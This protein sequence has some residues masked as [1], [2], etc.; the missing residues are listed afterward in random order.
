MCVIYLNCFIL[1]KI[2]QKKKTLWVVFLF[3][4]VYRD[5]RVF[6]FNWLSLVCDFF[7]V[8]AIVSWVFYN[9]DNPGEITY[10][11]QIWIIKAV[12]TW[13]LV[14]IF[15]GGPICGLLFFH[16]IEDNLGYTHY[17]RIRDYG[18]CGVIF[19]S[20]PYLLGWF[21]VWI[22]LSAFA[23]VLCE[24]IFFAPF[25]F[26]CW[27]V[28]HERFVDAPA[29]MYAKKVFDFILDNKSM[30]TKADGEY[31]I[32]LRDSKWLEENT[33]YTN[34]MHND[35][36]NHLQFRDK[37]MLNT[38]KK[39]RLFRLAYANYFL[40]SEICGYKSDVK[41]A[42]YL[43]DELNISN[44]WQN[45]TCATLRQ[46]C[47]DGP[48]DSAF[49]LR[50]KREWKEMM[51]DF[52]DDLTVDLHGTNMGRDYSDIIWDLF[53]IIYMYFMTYVGLPLFFLSRLFS[54]FFPVISMVYLQFDL[55][56]VSLLQLV[57]TV[58][59]GVLIFWWIIAL[60]KC[61]QFYYWSTHLFPGDESM[62]W[63]MAYNI[64]FNLRRLNLMQKYYNLRNDAVF[65]EPK[66]IEMVI[67]ILG[68]DIGGLVVSFWPKIQFKQFWNQL[69]VEE[70]FMN[71]RNG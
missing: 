4:F 37:R 57:F 28:A 62:S 20:L 9:P 44:S 22:L 47:N 70:A 8:F 26:A 48:V 49:W 64:K 17:V 36:F 69:K 27:M 10:L 65:V 29:S 5:F 33:D 12:I 16:S 59:Y 54:M 32:H 3:L 39:E 67:N 15:V 31:L 58:T 60:V 53:R 1:Y 18:K 45:V 46:N 68:K 52:K 43:R 6:I 30:E 25:A 55:K 19:Y 23:T 38:S 40:G 51:S 11:G 66:R 61:M 41:L 13:G 56:S 21:I 7:G 24:V 14:C 35:V 2:N 34:T 50:F 63:K 42:S 71:V